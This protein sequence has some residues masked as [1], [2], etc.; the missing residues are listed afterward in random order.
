MPKVNGA[1]SVSIQASFRGWGGNTREY[2]V[3]FEPGA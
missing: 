1:A 3:N 2:F